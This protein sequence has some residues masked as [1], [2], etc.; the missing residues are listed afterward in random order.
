MNLG[1]LTNETFIEIVVYCYMSFI[2]LY[3][4]MMPILSYSYNQRNASNNINAEGTSTCCDTLCC[5]VYYFF[6]F[7]FFISILFMV[8]LKIIGPVLLVYDLIE[9]GRAHLAS[10]STQTPF[11]AL[12]I[13]GI[14]GP[15]TLF[16]IVYILS[17]CCCRGE[18]E[19]VQTDQTEQS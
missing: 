8:L 1:F 3:L 18:V 14:F 4:I 6:Q 12:T 15:M 5:F 17:C 2:I 13:I 7:L 9:V 19:E 16:I 11:Y 10:V